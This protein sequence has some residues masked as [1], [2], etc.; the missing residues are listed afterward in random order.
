MIR[1]FSIPLAASALLASS[2][3][4]QDAP[5]PQP[6]PEAPDAPKPEAPKP[7]APKDGNRRN[8]EQRDANAGRPVPPPPLDGER[9]PPP[10]DR[11]G[12]GFGGPPPGGPRGGG[13][14]DGNRRPM[15]GPGEPR[16]GRPEGD[17][18]PT[19]TDR[20]PEGFGRSGYGERFVERAVKTPYIGVVTST[21]SPALA[22]Q[23]GLNE[24][25]GLVVDDVLAESPAQAAG[26][27]KYDVLKLVNDQQL[28]DPSQLS[29]LLRGFG[30]DTEVSITFIRKGQEQKIGTKIGEKMM[31]E[32][33]PGADLQRKFG[34]WGLRPQRESGDGPRG[35]GLQGPQPDQMH[36]FQ[37]RMQRFQDD[38]RQYQEQIR[39]WQ[40]DRNAPLPEPPRPPEF[41]QDRG[42]APSG[43]GDLL[44]EA[45]PGGA[46]KL[47]LPQTD[48][49]ST[50]ETNR[51]RLVMK[52][53]DG[54]VEVTMHE[55]K[56]TLTA[57]N[58]KGEVLFAGPIDTPE[59]HSA[60]PPQFRV[61]LDA[62]ETQQ[63]NLAAGAR[64]N[65]GRPDAAPFP[66]PPPPI[67]DEP[68]VQ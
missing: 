5:R 66:P 30:K 1:L 35:P 43:P 2:L 10:P 38:M 41:E 34:T 53:N 4:A 25:F 13:P 44:R 18:P 32:R 60:V 33:R 56:R 9:P 37:E 20:L 42:E 47:R 48:G 51:S 19:R 23:L 16:D 27:Q 26:L 6:A 31:T 49:V 3:I 17:R 62:I 22:A 15:P 28:I 50:F 7:E 46:P 68:E 67:P 24:G 29:K 57:R 64:P 8:G 65:T 14:R 58:L 54:E 39:V 59:Q 63:R 21:V 36:H 45:R 61:K 12:P 52:D 55:G 11:D 40:K